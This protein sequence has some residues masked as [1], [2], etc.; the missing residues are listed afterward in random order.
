MYQSSVCKYVRFP[1][2]SHTIIIRPFQCDRLPPCVLMDSKDGMNSALSNSSVR[3]DK[4]RQYIT[5]STKHFFSGFSSHP[6]HHPEASSSTTST[7]YP[8]YIPF[9]K[10]LNTFSHL[11][12]PTKHIIPRA[13]HTMVLY[14]AQ[15]DCAMHIVMMSGWLE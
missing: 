8:I 15:M 2:V 1:L 12:K 4:C 9:F 3:P 14:C 13:T 5:K 11:Y 6:P 10:E 7:T